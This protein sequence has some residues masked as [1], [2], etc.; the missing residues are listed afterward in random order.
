MRLTCCPVSAAYQAGYSTALADVLEYLQQNLD[1]H[2]QASG[3][4][5]VAIAQVI[6][7]IEV[8]IPFGGDQPKY[9][10]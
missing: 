9:R 3:A 8:G 1:V 7:Y 2:Q 10:Y 4:E 6:D 5:G